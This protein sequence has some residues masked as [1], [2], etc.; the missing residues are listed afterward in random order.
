LPPDRS[1]SPTP[2][3]QHARG[4]SAEGSPWIEPP[5]RRCWPTTWRTADGEEGG[6]RVGEKIRITHNIA[7]V[8][9]C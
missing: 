2:R 5:Y 9:L 3:G 8:G 1:S 4:V 7:C 6:R